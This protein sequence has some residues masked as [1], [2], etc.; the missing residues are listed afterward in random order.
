M[1]GQRTA[2][3][4]ATGSVRTRARRRH[5]QSSSIA[6]LVLSDRGCLPLSNQ[7]HARRPAWQRQTFGLVQLKTDSAEHLQTIAV[8]QR[9]AEAILLRTAQRPQA[10]DAVR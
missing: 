5:E 1:Q 9:Q 6:E 4:A 2:K 7:N 8:R 10:G 3:T